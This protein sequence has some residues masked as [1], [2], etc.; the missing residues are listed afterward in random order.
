MDRPLFT[1]V[2]I[3]CSAS[4]S[5]PHALVHSSLRVAQDEYN[6]FSYP[7]CTQRMIFGSGPLS[8]TAFLPGG[9]GLTT[10]P[11]KAIDTTQI[12]YRTQGKHQPVSCM[13]EWVHNCISAPESAR[14][15]LEQLHSKKSPKCRPRTKDSL[16]YSLVTTTA[17]A[18]QI[19]HN[20]Q[21]PP[22]L[23]ETVSDGYRLIS[24]HSTR[25]YVAFR[26]AF[27]N[28]TAISGLQYR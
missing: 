15:L 1:F 10:S 21:H 4:P 16:H 7:D 2:A 9:F 11:Q 27:A 8:H 14:Q 22:G 13:H 12:P 17:S 3:H 6:P 19:N 20:R 28:S 26:T 23:Y 24:F 5:V 25:I 18:S